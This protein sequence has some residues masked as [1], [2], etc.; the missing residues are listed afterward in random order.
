MYIKRAHTVYRIFGKLY[1][2]FYYF[3][4][5]AGFTF[6]GISVV[7]KKNSA[8]KTSILRRIFSPHHFLWLLPFF[9]F[10]AGY[11]IMSLSSQTE[12]IQTP[13][14]IG[15]TSA[16][17]LR[18]CAQH[19]A[20]LRILEEKVDTQLPDG[21]VIA[22]DPAPGTAIKRDGAI[23]C[24]LSKK[25][26]AVA[27]ALIGLTQEQIKHKIAPCNIT[28]TFVSVTST[29]PQGTCI[30][31]SPQA[32]KTIPDGHLIAY[33]AQPAHSSVIM[34]SFEQHFLKDALSF[35]QDHECIAELFFDTPHDQHHICGACMVIG[36]H[37]KAGALIASQNIKNMHV[38]LAVHCPA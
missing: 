34:P 17:A 23:W 1:V 6:R 37:P 29:H 38:Q 19:S 31:Q 30:A 3:P 12:S 5:F 36:Q 25:I 27:P 2:L 16:E 20:T 7:M 13:K 10:L 35:L 8:N 33:M 9:G 14:L 26:M 11:L 21:T 18:I 28:C 32:Q 24:T 22:Q 4:L 15:K